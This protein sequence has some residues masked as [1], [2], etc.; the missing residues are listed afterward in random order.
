[1]SAVRRVTEGEEEE[2]EE[3]CN[4]EGCETMNLVEP[5][6]VLIPTGSPFQSSALIKHFRPD[7]HVA[8]TGSTCRL[9]LLDS[10]RVPGILISFLLWSRSTM[11]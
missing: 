3:G 7:F 6:H 9:A 2:Q 5:Y 8:M 1:M 4:D 10:S 11:F